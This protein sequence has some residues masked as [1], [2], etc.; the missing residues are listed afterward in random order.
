MVVI[1]LLLVA[2]LAVVALLAGRRTKRSTV[3][4]WNAMKRIQ[5]RIKDE[6]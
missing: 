2:F 4:E 6:E 1:V 3:D 5:D